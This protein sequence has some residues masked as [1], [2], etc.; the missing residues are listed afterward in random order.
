MQSTC[1][2]IFT[3]C[4]GYA[5]G[6]VEGR[7]AIQYFEDNSNPKRSFA[8]KCHRQGNK[9]FA[10]N[11]ISF[12]SLGTF[13]TSGGDGAYVFWDKDTKKK[14]RSYER[15]NI[16]ITSTDFNGD[17][18]IFA[19]ASSYDWSKGVNKRDPTTKISLHIVRTDDIKKN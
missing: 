15:S 10:V 7:V 19:Y 5:L 1:I 2:E 14:I 12:N 3:D 11:A 13:S 4:K 18:S 17:N 8:F 6:S 9:V 16:S